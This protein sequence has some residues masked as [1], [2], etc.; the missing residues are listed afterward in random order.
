MHPVKPYH[1]KPRKG[2]RVWIEQV[3]MTDIP[4]GVD[5][6][7]FDTLNIPSML[8]DGWT[9]MHAA[10]HEG[11]QG[12]ASIDLINGLAG[13]RIELLLWPELVVPENRAIPTHLYHL[14]FSTLGG[15]HYTLGYDT[16]E[17]A[18]AAYVDFSTYRNVFRLAI[19]VRG[20]TL[21]DLKWMA[22]DKEITDIDAYHEALSWG[23]SEIILVHVNTTDLPS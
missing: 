10:P 4:V 16:V 15:A 5:P 19:K 2:E 17:E 11:E 3:K 21:C 23:D 13:Q 18:V 1:R 22:G 7:Q 12:L 9:V 14:S 20:M 8:V 6:R